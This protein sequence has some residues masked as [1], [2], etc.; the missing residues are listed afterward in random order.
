VG[1]RDYFRHGFG[2]ELDGHHMSKKLRSGI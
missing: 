1:A 2:Y